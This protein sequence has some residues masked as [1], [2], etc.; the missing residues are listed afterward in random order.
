MRKIFV[1]SLSLVNFK[2]V[3]E[4]DLQFVDG[5]NMIGGSNGTGKTTVFD[6]FTWLMFGKDSTGRSDSNFNIKTL[7]D[8]GKP[9]YHLD[10][11]V[12][13]VMCVD[14][15]D[16]KLERKYVEVW[17]KQSGTTDMFL[18]N[19]KTEFFVNDVKCATK[20]EY[21]A[22]VNEIIN[23]SVYKMI[24]N[25]WYFPQLSADNQ[26]SMLIDMAGE[27]SDEDVA[28]TNKNFAKFLEDLNGKPME[29]MAKEI[30]AKKRA[31]NEILDRIP[32]QIETAENVM[33]EAEDWDAIDAEIKN[34]LKEIEDIDATIADKSKVNE[35]EYER[36]ASIQN[37]IGDAKLELA[38]VKNEIRANASQARNVAIQEINNIQLQIQGNDN[39]IK[40]TNRL[41]ENQ[42]KEIESKEINVKALREEYKKVFASMI[43]FEDGQFICPTCKRPY[44]A[45]EIEAKK[46]ELTE[47]F[48]TDKADK[49]KK[50]QEKGK[51][52]NAALA[53]MKQ[54]LATYKKE[55]AK[56]EESVLTLQK[57]KS[58]KEAEMPEPVDEANIIDTDQRVIDLQ[59]KIVDLENQLNVGIKVIDVSELREQKRVAN[60]A[61]QGLYKRAAKKEQI[62]RTRKEIE[63]LEKKQASNN[64]V[65]AD[66][67]QWE[68]LHIQFQKAKDEELLK[69]INGMFEVVSFSFLSTQL[70]GNE[71]LTCVCTVNGTPYPDVNNAGKINAG[72]DIIN[73]IC[74]A[75][76]VT[77]PIFVDNAESVND[78]L[79]TYSQKIMLYVTKDSTIR[80]I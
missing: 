19:H 41:I 59:N 76:G 44:D 11:S 40:S 56:H 48:N 72:L 39:M 42:E 73:A 54:T 32:S 6:A 65:L 43:E 16:V 70:N 55:L 37:Q 18:K 23:E 7:D 1:K 14:G 13:A 2:G 63:D 30:Q 49:L 64:Q 38:N 68:R 71:K 8:A 20:K 31:C 45:A 62:E 78:I 58:E 9:I 80:K 57:K 24:T 28:A 75:K 21:D 51:A 61:L 69:R 17:Q 77:A 5:E 29:K 10:H 4:L 33:P 67:E 34:K 3:R 79:K 53:E 12:V 60:E 46:K 66:C 22:E 47:N 27:V 26:K 15:T 25:P 36:K 35:Q 50:I 74:K 52:L